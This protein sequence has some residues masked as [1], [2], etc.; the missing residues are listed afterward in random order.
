MGDVDSV[1]HMMKTDPNA[2][3]AACL[4]IINSVLDT[5]TREQLIEKAA[6]GGRANRNKYYLQPIENWR[7]AHQ[8]GVILDNSNHIIRANAF[9]VNVSALPAKVY[10]YHV[11][12]FRYDRENNLREEDLAKEKDTAMN[13]GI[14]KQVI[15]EHKEW[16]LNDRTNDAVGLAYD[17]RSSFYS[18]ALLPLPHDS[19][20]HA[21]TFDV[22]YPP[23]TPNNYFLAISLVENG[24]VEI[25]RTNG[26][27]LFL[28]NL[29]GFK[30]LIIFIF[31]QMRG[32][33]E[34]IKL[35]YKSWTLPWPVSHVGNNLKSIHN[36]F[37]LGIKSFAQMELFSTLVRLIWEDLV[38]ISP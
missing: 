29:Y 37:C 15:S 14:V 11:S 13:I 32:E 28:R 16:K 27:N 8:V 2:N 34:Q 3:D 21:A 9:K 4:R 7:I 6:S 35:L 10:H 20:G 17:G 24:E 36:G 22:T 18:T 1:M 33:K 26:E 12:I 19:D 25:P 23:N 38:I 31:V 5:V 30:F